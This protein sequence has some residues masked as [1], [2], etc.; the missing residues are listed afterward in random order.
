M[1]TPASLSPS[2]VMLLVTLSVAPTTNVPFEM[3]TVSPVAAALMAVWIFPPAGTL[4]VAG[5]AVVTKPR[6]ARQPADAVFSHRVLEMVIFSFIR[7]PP[8]SYLIETAEPVR[9]RRVPAQPFP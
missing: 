6:T 4:I 9:T 1:T 8:D 3:K 2:I 5:S 7:H